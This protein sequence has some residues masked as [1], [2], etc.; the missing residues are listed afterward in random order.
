MYVI[1]KKFFLAIIDNGI[2]CLENNWEICEFEVKDE[3]KVDCL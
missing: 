1:E 2:W 3:Q